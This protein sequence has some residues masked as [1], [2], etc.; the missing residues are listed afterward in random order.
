MKHQE[1][2]CHAFVTSLGNDSVSIGCAIISDADYPAKTAFLLINKSIEELTKTI[3][4][5]TLRN[6]N[7][8]ATFT[9]DTLQTL[10]QKF[11]D[12]SEADTTLKIQKVN[13]A[14]ADKIL[15]IRIWMKQKKP[16]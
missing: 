4:L 1:Y 7:Q 5:D 3:P 16:W 13:S 6:T 9:V 14:A 11:Q 12:P 15:N 2:F 10:I 8:D